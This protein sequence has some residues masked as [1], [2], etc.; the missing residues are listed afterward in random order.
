MP[1]FPSPFHF[2]ATPHGNG[3]YPYSGT[4]NA[5]NEK[6]AAEILIRAF[7]RSCVLA[8]RLDLVDSLHPSDI[9]VSPVR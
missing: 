6:D 9:S 5:A 1:R 3:T 7:N 8:G 4:V 2:H